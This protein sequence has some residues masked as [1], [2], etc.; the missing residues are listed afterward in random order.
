MTVHAPH[1]TPPCILTIAGSDS[2][3]GAGIQADLKAMTALGGFG[4][5]VITALTAQNGLGVTGIHAPDAE[6]VALQL[7]TV[8]DGFPVAGAK[9]GM[10][11]SAPIIEAV[12]DVL[13]ARKNFPLVVDPVSVSQSGHRLLRED[14]MQA[15]VRRVLPL[16]DLLTPNRPEAEMLAGMDIA[17][18]ADVRE[19]VRRILAMGPKAVLLKGG[20]FEGS[21]DLIDWLGL[22]GPLPGTGGA[23]EIIALSQPRVDTPNNHGTGCTLSAA[24]AT[25]LGLGMDLLPAVQR[26]QRYLNL[27]LRESYTPGQGFGPPNH[28]APLTLREF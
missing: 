5:S 7:T 13:A 18:E 27:C 3:G 21:G 9:T 10:L 22:S 8:L 14:A 25:C 12:A 23:P 19:A 20:H 28:A 16:A 26:A 17:T 24:I 4:M 6:F 11:F 15:L 1:A 2:G